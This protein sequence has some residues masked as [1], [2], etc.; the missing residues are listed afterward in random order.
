M[1]RTGAILAVGVLTGL[2][3]CKLP[4]AAP[5]MLAESKQAL[6]IGPEA[7]G[8][9]PPPVD[10]SNKESGRLCLRTAQEFEKSGQ[11]D[12]AIGLYERARSLDSALAPPIGRRLAVLY[13][14]VGNF[15]KSSVEY[16]ALLKTSP[17][18]ADLLN[19][20]GYSYYCRGDWTGA[21]SYLSRAIQADPKHKRAYINLGLALAQQEK[22]EEAFQAFCKAVRPA[23]AH[24]NLAFVLSAKGQTD[25]AKEQYRKALALDPGL[26]LA[27]L[28]LGRLENPQAAGA[29]SARKADKYDLAEA[30]A[31]VPTVEEIEARMRRAAA[32][33]TPIPEGEPKPVMPD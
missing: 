16:D 33:S 8:K 15:A 1:S 24:C 6:L 29:L 9:A 3:G 27:Q 19:D 20:Y 23:D 13:D 14:Q 4:Q 17:K 10:L 2:T 11:L 5:G 31:K 32:V 21:E 22:W 12:D 18:D 26:R 30:A 7:A 28:A 25:Q